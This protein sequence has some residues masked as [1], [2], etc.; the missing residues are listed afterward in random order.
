MHDVVSLFAV[1]IP[2]YYRAY[3]ELQIACKKLSSKKYIH[4]M[5]RPFLEW[6]PCQGFW[7]FTWSRS[8]KIQVNPRNPAKFTKT[9]KMPRNSVE[10]LSNTCLYNIFETYFSYR[11]YLLAVNVQI[12][13]GTSSLKRANNVL[14]P[15]GIDYVVKN[16]ALAMMLKALPLVHFWSVLLLKEQ[17]MTPVRK[18]LNQCKTNQFLAKFALKVTTKSAVFYWLLFGKVPL[19]LPQNS[20]EIGRFFLEFVPK[21]PAKFDFFFRDLSEA[22]ALWVNSTTTSRKGPLNLCILGGWLWAVWLYNYNV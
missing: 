15:P 12:Y 18:T 9:R 7:Y 2:H 3:K 22:L 13:L 8:R 5:S 20:R 6:D 16:W 14:K 11:G 10:I 19:K 21:N 1:I 17:M 4:S